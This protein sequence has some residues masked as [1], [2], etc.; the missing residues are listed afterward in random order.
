MIKEGIIIARGLIYIYHDLE[1]N[2][3]KDTDVLV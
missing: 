1:K 2:K 3:N